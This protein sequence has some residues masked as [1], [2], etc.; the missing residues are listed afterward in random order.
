[1]KRMA[2]TKSMGDS[3]TP[4]D[5]SG[6]RIIHTV[7]ET[8]A[9]TSRSSLDLLALPFPFSQVS[10]LTADE[11]L[12]AAACR[13][14]KMR[15]D[16]DLDI[17]GLEELHKHE[18][19]VPMFG[20]GIGDGDPTRRIDTT[21]SSTRQHLH[22]TIISQLYAAAEDGRL[23]DPS[24]EPFE[25]WP[26]ERARTLWPSKERGYLYS[27]HQ[28]LGLERA[29]SLV[30]A[31]RPTE[32]VGYRSI[33]HL[34]AIDLPNDR[35]KRGLAS[36]RSLAITL[37]AIDT[38]VWPFITQVIF[39]SDEVWRSTNLSQDPGALL[40]WLGISAKH[41]R[42]QALDL[43]VSADFDDVLGDFYDLVRRANPRAWMTLRGEARTAMDSRMAAEALDRF[44]DELPEGEQAEAPQPKV[45]LSLQGL[46]VR[47]RSLDAVL[48]DL[49]VSPH[50]ALVIGLEGAT[51][52]SIVPRVMKVLGIRDDPTRMRLVNFGGTKTSL[53]LL[54]RF[55]AEPVLGEDYGE[56]VML[57]RPV[58]RFL[59]LTDAENNYKTPE[60]R[61]RQRK[62]LLDSI[63]TPL[64]RDLRHDLYSEEACLVEIMT[65]GRYP[66]EFAHFT[67]DE[68][69]DGLLQVAGKPY[70]DSRAGLIHNIHRLRVANAAPNIEHAWTRSGVSKVE[71][72]DALWPILEARI[73]RAVEEATAVPP[74]M[75]AMLRAYELASLSYGLNMTVRRNSP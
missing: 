72:A 73:K 64:P 7:S 30:G 53:A 59:V 43:R 34:D 21:H 61:C 33:W 16:R 31:L 39:N 28:L 56:S 9:A 52:M 37:S 48:T 70:P 45:N 66:W 6:V 41:L 1:M 4:S 60:A 71:L 51:E 63:I 13:R 18:V 68:L 19:L 29:R 25:E 58:T 2:E 8:V 26:T 24:T 74:V 10:L 38:R 40:D 57:D 32:R 62:L 54:A 22:T 65:W 69:A 47:E 27:Y 36:W 3:E 11:F 50:P 55:A 12:K 14:I 49:Q 15:A 42:D 75:K 5:G 44:T 35:A 23:T 46:S 17:S 67:D 20:V